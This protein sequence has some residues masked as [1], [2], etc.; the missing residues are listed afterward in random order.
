VSTCRFQR[1]LWSLKLVL[2][3]VTVDQC[4]T[5][6]TAQCC[7][8]VGQSKDRKVIA[9]ASELGVVVGI[10]DATVGLLCNPLSAFTAGGIQW[11]GFSLPLRSLGV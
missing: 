4:N 9:V 6:G 1:V 2:N 5:V 8:V 11:Y 3:R 10:A 7:N